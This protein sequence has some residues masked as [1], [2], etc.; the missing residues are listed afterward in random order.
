MHLA[1]VEELRYNAVLQR[2]KHVR[3]SFSLNNDRSRAKEIAKVYEAS[4]NHNTLAAPRVPNKTSVPNRPV[5]PALGTAGL[6]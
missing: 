5:R 3:S 1:C 4:N 6:A 2:E